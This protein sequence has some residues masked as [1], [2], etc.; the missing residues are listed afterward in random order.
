MRVDCYNAS[1]CPI[2]SIQYGDTF[3]HQGELYLRVNTAMKHS[4]EDETTCWAVA[5]GDGML[6][7]FDADGSVTLADTKVVVNTK[8]VSF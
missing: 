8:D 3:Y 2:S 6:M 4:L 1:E 5:L 7:P